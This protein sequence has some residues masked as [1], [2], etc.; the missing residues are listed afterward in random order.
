MGAGLA[1]Q[2]IAHLL[3][4]AA[5]R[6]A[7]LRADRAAAEAYGASAL[8]NALRKIDAASA[9][10][11]ADLSRGTAAAYAHLM[12]SDG[13]QSTKARNKGLLGVLNKVGAALRTHPSLDTRVAA[14]EKAAADGLVPSRR[15]SS[16]MSWL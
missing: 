8:V 12:I 9:R 14:L 2:G 10:R 16:Y 15:P 3:R 1:C 11:P 4:L 7:E 5:S 13:P 6:G